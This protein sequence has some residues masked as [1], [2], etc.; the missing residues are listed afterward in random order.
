VIFGIVEIIASILGGNT[1]LM[2]LRMAASVFLGP[3]AITAVSLGT[4]A[5]VGLLVHFAVSAFYGLIYGL[6][7]TR[8]SGAERTRYGTQAWA[9]FVFGLGVWLV[10][11][12]ILAR[13]FYPWFLATPQFAQALLHAVFFGMPLAL[14]YA[15]GERRA[16]AHLRER[17]V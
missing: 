10:N 4:A 1:P 3:E 14:M 13:L 11:F 15:A 9:G 12:Q 5:V 8:S 7:Q 16:H 2:P 6:I 17:H